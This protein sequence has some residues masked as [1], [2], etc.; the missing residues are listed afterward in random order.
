MNVSDL[1]NFTRLEIYFSNNQEKTQIYSIE[2]EVQQQNWRFFRLWTT[3]IQ[4]RCKKNSPIIILFASPTR[5]ILSQRLF[6]IIISDHFE[7]CF[8]TKIFH[9]CQWSF[10][11]IFIIF[12]Y[13]NINFI[14]WLKLFAMIKYSMHWSQL[15]RG[16]DGLK[17][18]RYEFE[19]LESENSLDKCVVVRVVWILFALTFKSA[20]VNPSVFAARPAKQMSDANVSLRLSARRMDRRSDWR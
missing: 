6:N 11:I 19:K 18:E 12:T 14:I 8:I 5:M 10:V 13:A 16:E 20:P 9:H 17:R 4:K 2:N 7:W 1:K 15:G 3:F